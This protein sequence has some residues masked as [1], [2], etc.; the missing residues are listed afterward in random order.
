M[1]TRSKE[2][3]L[4]KW[5]INNKCCGSIRIVLPRQ[6]EATTRSSLATCS[7]CTEYSDV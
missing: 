2:V 4:F 7:D 1:I 5:T 3:H 6:S